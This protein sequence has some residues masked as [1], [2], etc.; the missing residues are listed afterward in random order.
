MKIDLSADFYEDS[1]IESLIFKIC[2]DLMPK[3]F[4]KKDYGNNDVE[5]FMVVNCVP[6]QFKLRKRY[7]SKSKV[8]YWDIIL[9]YKAVKKA[10]K[11]EKQVILANSIIASFDILDGYKKLNINKDN[12][13]K[14]A[15]SFF[16]KLGW[17]PK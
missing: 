6:H 5:I 9:D 17:L 14:D 11:N 16:E 15:H 3:Y 10:K 1:G 4:R 7:D 2:G 13:K 8:L 12:L